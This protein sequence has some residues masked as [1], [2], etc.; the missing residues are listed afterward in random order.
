MYNV[1]Y[2]LLTSAQSM[3]TVLLGSIFDPQILLTDTSVIAVHV[4]PPS[5]KGP[6][7]A[8][9]LL[10]QPMSYRL[11][12]LKDPSPITLLSCED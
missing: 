7:G 3:C 11:S 10:N 5:L 2:G 12:L 9:V 4:G 6:G 8:K 1:Q